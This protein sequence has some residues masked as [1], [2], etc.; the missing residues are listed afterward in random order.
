MILAYLVFLAYI[1]GFCV[2]NAQLGMI[3]S[4]R[5]HYLSL[6]KRILSYSWPP[7]ITTKSAAGI[8]P[9]FF[10][11]PARTTLRTGLFYSSGV[12]PDCVNYH[13]SFLG[14][15]GDLFG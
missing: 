5:K 13:W 8:T 2:G 14:L 12:P 4:C 9:A 15:D 7:I 10:I 6:S 3:H 11:L 1:C